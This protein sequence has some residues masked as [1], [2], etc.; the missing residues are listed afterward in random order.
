M[1]S[2]EAAA[3]AA[4]AVVFSISGGDTKLHMIKTAANARKTTYKKFHYK[5]GE[6]HLNIITEV[7][8]VSIMMPLYTH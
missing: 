2:A 4:A 7:S 5:I 6:K 3:A 1:Q 8:A